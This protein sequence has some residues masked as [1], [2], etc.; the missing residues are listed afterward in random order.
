M[1]DD[2][3]HLAGDPLALVL[4]CESVAEVRGDGTLMR[5]LAGAALEHPAQGT[6]PEE[7]RAHDE[8]DR[9]RDPPR[10]RALVPSG[11]LG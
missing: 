11:G 5:H 4:R 7:D 6:G 3:V 8:T 10:R 9:H 1:A 2:V